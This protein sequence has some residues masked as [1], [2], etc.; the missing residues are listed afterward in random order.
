MAQA[1]R[2]FAA[3]RLRSSVENADVRGA[4]ARWVA[5]VA[6]PCRFRWDPGSPE[7]PRARLE[8]LKDEQLPALLWAREHEPRLHLELASTLALPMANSGRVR[9]SCEEL[10]VA[11]ER[12][13]VEGADAAWAAAVQAVH[14]MFLHGPEN[15][16]PDTDGIETALRSAGDDET[17]EVGLRILSL[18]HTKAGDSDRAT[19]ASGES[20]AIARRGG[21]PELLFAELVFHAQ[22]LV[23]AGRLDEADACTREA[24]ALL[25]DLPSDAATLIA[26]IRGDLA[27]AREDWPAALVEYAAH[28]AGAEDLQHPDNLVLALKGVLLGFGGLARWEAVIELFAILDDLCAEIG[29]SITVLPEWDERLAR[30]R[31]EAAGAIGEA[32]AASAAQRGHGLRPAE[33]TARIKA[34]AS[35]PVPA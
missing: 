9:D 34:L 16:R 30:L 35:S 32:E 21:S 17:L 24:A 26:S 12:Y 27:Q 18:T 3:E 7:E 10:A 5:E 22:A 20:V 2:D 31:V 23:A 4:H 25:P 19:T 1:V 6:A 29:R 11:L 14:I 8:A 33:R 13:G 15:V 28:A